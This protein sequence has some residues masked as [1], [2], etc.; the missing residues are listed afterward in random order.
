ML[1]GDIGF[2]EIALLA[3]LGLLVLGPEK[4]PKVARTIGGYVRKGRQAWDSVR[5]E[6]EA[7]LSAEELKRSL[8][9]PVDELNKLRA[10]ARK[11]AEETSKSLEQS[12][13]A[14]DTP[15][16]PQELETGPE[17]GPAASE[18]PDLPTEAAP[19]PERP[20]PPSDSS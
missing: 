12:V 14:L 10:S 16:P 5:S 4:L 13:E 19:D 1:P 7:E 20:N 15:E 8:Q 6:I 9:E 2:S 18:H 11:T 3:V 17:Q